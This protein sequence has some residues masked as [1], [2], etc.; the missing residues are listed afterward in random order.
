MVV[1]P[2]PP[3]CDRTAIVIALI[4]A[5]SMAGRLRMHGAG[6]PGRLHAFRPHGL[7]KRSVVGGSTA[8][9]EPSRHLLERRLD[10]LGFEDHLGPG[11]TQRGQAGGGVHLIAAPIGGLLG[12]RAVI[13]Q[14]VRLDHEAKLGPMEVDPESVDVLLRQGL[15]QARLAR[16]WKEPALELGIGEGEGPALEDCSEGRD[17]ALASALVEREAKGLRIDQIESIGRIDRFLD[18]LAARTHGEIYQGA[19]HARYGNVV[20]RAQIIGSEP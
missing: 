18:L 20:A 5:Q 4:E 19:C 7:Q 8:R 6:A 16:Q 1:F 14:P 13:A 9:A 15:R 3:F 17:P 2:V 12:R 10:V 11:E